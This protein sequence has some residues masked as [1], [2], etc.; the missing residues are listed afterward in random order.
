M[1]ETITRII[2]S[3]RILASRRISASKPIL[4]AAIIAALLMF[5][6]G[7][8][9][10]SQSENSKEKEAF[11]ENRISI[12]WTSGDPAVAEH[13]VMPYSFYSKKAGWFD[14]VR[15]IVWGPSSKLLSESEAF[16]KKIAELQ[17]AGVIV[18]ACVVC[19]DSYGVSDQFREMGIEVIP[20][21]E[22]LSDRLKSD[23][24]WKVI[25]F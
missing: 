24:E 19:A 8:S 16:Q 7:G 3:T 18:E 22:P 23:G 1:R 12:L 6:I 2:A 17:E 11:G 10:L 4:S 25:T 13:V 9:A 20:M 5:V 21:G 14:E 15:L